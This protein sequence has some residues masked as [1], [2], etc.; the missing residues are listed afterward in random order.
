M[1]VTLLRVYTNE[2]VHK[3]VLT[4]TN[5][6]TGLIPIPGPLKWEMKIIAERYPGGNHKV[7]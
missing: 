5:G 1:P 6:Q 3:Q 4:A 7:S 2:K